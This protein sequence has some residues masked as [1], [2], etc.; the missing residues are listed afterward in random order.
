MGDR[1]I[2]VAPTAMTS[3]TRSGLI[4][5]HGS[6]AEEDGEHHQDREDHAPRPHGGDIAT[7]PHGQRHDAHPAQSGSRG[8]TGRAQ[9]RGDAQSDRPPGQHQGGG[10]DPHTVHMQP[11]QGRDQRRVDAQAGQQPDRSL[12]KRLEEHEGMQHG[13]PCP[14]QAQP[15]QPRIAPPRGQ[16]G[17][18]ASE[19]HERQTENAQRLSAEG[20]VQHPHPGLG[21]VVA[22]TGA[23]PAGARQSRSGTGSRRSSS[24]SPC[25]NTK[26]KC[27]RRSR[28][29]SS[30]DSSWTATELS[31][32]RR[33]TC[34]ESGTEIPA[35]AWSSV[36]F[37]EP[38]G[39]VIAT[40]SHGGDR[41]AHPVQGG[42]RSVVLCEVMGVE[43]SSCHGSTMRRGASS[44][45]RTRVWSSCPSPRPVVVARS[46]R[47][48]APR[49]T[50]RP[51]PP[52]S[53]SY[54]QVWRKV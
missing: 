39:P 34:P 9:Q 20:P 10:P 47:H 13:P 21:V 32:V 3:R 2:T 44:A 48:P 26:P 30:A 51:S 16:L 42:R 8:E 18:S 49:M 7:G 40:D 24:S 4:D 5:Q 25:W 38:E 19:L 52:G 14:Q 35:R 50:P 28:A 36:V 29:R 12:E 43:N 22:P 1:T 53:Q 15:G 31:A 6:P 41:E 45:H 27:S 33:R 37:P 46:D 54:P 17:R 11:A 23:R